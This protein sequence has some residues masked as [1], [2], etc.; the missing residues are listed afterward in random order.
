MKKILSVFL[1]AVLLSALMTVSAIAQQSTAEITEGS[2]TEAISSEPNTSAESTDDVSDGTSVE[3]TEA[4]AFEKVFQVIF[5][6][7]M[8]IGIVGLPT[9][10]W[11]NARRKKALEE[12]N[13]S[14]NN[15]ENE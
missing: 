4:S 13:E 10:Y 3:P 7:I 9:Y 15:D 2:V 14:Q 5:I 6:A 11:L 12:Y 8:T 1:I